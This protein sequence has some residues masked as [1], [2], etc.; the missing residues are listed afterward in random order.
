MK[1]NI[2]RIILLLMI[3]VI[4]FFN[5][6]QLYLFTDKNDNTNEYKETYLP[7]SS[8]NV[9]DVISYIDELI[10]K[11][12][13][14]EEEKRLQLERDEKFRLFLDDIK[15]GKLTFRK[16]FSDTL[17][18]GD[19]LMQG[20]NTYRVLDSSNMIS[21]VSASLY[22]LEGN[23]EKIIA[24]NPKKLVTHYGINMLVDSEG[25]LNSFILQYERIIIKLKNSL[26]DT[27]I[28][29]SGIFNVAPSVEKRYSAV[30]KYNNRLREM[31][32]DL[33]VFY[34]DNSSCLPGDGKYYGSDGIHVSKG[35]YTDVWLPHLYYE[36]Y[37]R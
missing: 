23:I 5:W 7:V 4:P 36:I 22:H 30:E 11:R 14:E 28:F 37:L 1:K 18:V 31:C 3:I 19:S 15:S 29:I 25:Y 32:E 34:L 33:D 17:I 16:V 10:E 35:F 26:P 9:N 12:E 27:E 2:L 6:V 13:K 20:L 21:M 24:N 8:L